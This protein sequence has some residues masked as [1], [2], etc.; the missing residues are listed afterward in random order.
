MFFRKSSAA[1]YN[2]MPVPRAE[3]AY[4]FLL[5]EGVDASAVDVLTDGR[6]GPGQM[7]CG[8]R[9]SAVNRRM[10]DRRW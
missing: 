3:R 5:A 4:G 2:E 8:V 7:W 1:M 9:G 6:F 10:V